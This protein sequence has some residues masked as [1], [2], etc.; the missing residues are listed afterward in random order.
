MALNQFVADA[1]LR[2][3]GDLTAGRAPSIGEYSEQILSEGRPK[4]AAQ[5]GSTRY[6][7]DAVFVE[8]IFPAPGTTSTVLTVRL[9]TLERIVFMPVPTWVVESI[10]QGEI[11]GSFH[12]ESD[13]ERLLADFTNQLSPDHNFGL[14]GDKAP[15]RRG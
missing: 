15:T 5:M 10:W 3:L 7:P 13:A 11:D 1:R 8:F 6:Q 4:G 2:I 14:F 9:P 12:F